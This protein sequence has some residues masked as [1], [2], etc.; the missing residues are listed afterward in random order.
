MAEFTTLTSFGFSD[1]TLPGWHVSW[2]DSCHQWRIWCKHYFPQ[3]GSEK[4]FLPRWAGLGAW[5]RRLLGDPAFLSGHLTQGWASQ[6]LA[7]WLQSLGKYTYCLCSGLLLQLQH[8]FAQRRHQLSVWGDLS[9]V[10]C[11]ATSNSPTT[12]VFLQ[13]LLNLVPRRWAS[14]E[15]TLHEEGSMFGGAIASSQSDKG[16]V[17][18]ARFSKFS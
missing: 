17:Y 11:K 4:I 8:R 7:R 2:G 15:L 3:Q 10:P 9:A 6:T 16:E 12:H 18:E 14:A 1:P 5:W 13:L